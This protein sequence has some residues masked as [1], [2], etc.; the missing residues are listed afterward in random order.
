MSTTVGGAAFHVTATDVV[1]QAGGGTLHT[2]T[3]NTGATG[4]SVT[5][6][7]GPDASH[8]VIA[9]LAAAAVGS[10]AYDAVLTKGLYVSV[11]GAPDVTV[12][13]LPPPVYNP[14]EN[15]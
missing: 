3:V 5:L 8:P 1:A 2:V 15:V 13:I 14:W 9:V 11:S 7:D 4:A 12:V 6:Y 10:F